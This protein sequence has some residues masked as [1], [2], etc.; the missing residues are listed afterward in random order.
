MKK[1]KNIAIKTY[2]YEDGEAILAN[3]TDVE[4]NNYFI[5]RAT[6]K[7]LIYNFYGY[8]T[9]DNM[10]PKE[11]KEMLKGMTREEICKDLQVIIIE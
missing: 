5:R 1:I 2:C 8:F 10:S 3:E 4:S 6:K 7:Y 11:A 9:H